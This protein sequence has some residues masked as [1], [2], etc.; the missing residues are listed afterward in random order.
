MKRATAL[1][2]AQGTVRADRTV[3]EIEQLLDEMLGDVIVSKR[4]LHGEVIALAFTVPYT[5]AEGTAQKHVELPC[6]IDAMEKALHDCNLSPRGRKTEREWAVDVAWRQIKHWIE[7]QLLLTQS[8]MASPQE[9]FLPWVTTNGP[10]TPTLF[11]AYSE[12]LMLPAP[13]GE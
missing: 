6:N 5:G 4:R 7:A 11:A 10:G 13:K 3:G 2:Y 9:I 12:R 1:K 8:G